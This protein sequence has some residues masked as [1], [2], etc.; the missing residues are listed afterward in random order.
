VRV[1]PKCGYRDPPFWRPAAWRRNYEV[2]VCHI[3]DLEFNDPKLAARIKA[4][5]GEYISDETFTYRLPP[6]SPWVYRIWKKLYEI[7]GPS[8]FVRLEAHKPL[9]L[10]RKL[11][12]F[13]K[14]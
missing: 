12:E 5:Q 9:D 4:H 2:D 13:C 7:G 1:C 3:S 10:N 8:A 11:T 14:E 6:K